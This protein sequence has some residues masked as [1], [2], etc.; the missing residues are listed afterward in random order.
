M[1]KVKIQGNAAGTGVFSIVSPDS[2]TNRTLTLP[3][4]T[5]TLLDENSSVPAANLTGTVADA[6]FPATLPAKSGVNLTALNASNLGSGTLPDARFPATLP[7]ISATNL[8]AIPAANITGTLPAIDG[9]SLTGLAGNTPSFSAYLSANQ[10]V[11]D[12]VYTKMNFNTE[13]WDSDGAYATASSRFTVPTGAAGKYVI[14]VVM[15]LTGTAPIR[16]DYPIVIYKNG[17]GIHHISTNWSADVLRYSANF[18]WVIDL[19]EGDYIEPYTIH[20]DT[21]TDNV[22]SSGANNSQWSGFKLIGV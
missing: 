2:D 17:S 16:V 4:T 1:A 21:G 9:S 19:S 20:A 14:S 18:T 7:A 13:H 10:T 11:P 8:T 12:N 3:D 6:R 5:G 22:W 15:K